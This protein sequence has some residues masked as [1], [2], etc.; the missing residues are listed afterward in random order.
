VKVAVA[1]LDGDGQAEIIA[2]MASNGSQIEIY[3][4]DGTLL[5]KFEAFESHTGLVVTAG[6]VIGD[7][8]PEMVV[9]ELNGTVIR[10][11][12]SM[13]QSITCSSTGS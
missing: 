12:D 10:L 8:R 13:G 3:R 9:S 4:S 1:D 5:R 2:A 11:F 6:Q 7:S